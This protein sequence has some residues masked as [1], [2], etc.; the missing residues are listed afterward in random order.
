M[1]QT[2]LTQNAAG[3]VL[4]QPPARGHKPLTS[5]GSRTEP[6]QPRIVNLKELKENR[7]AAQ[8]LDQEWLAQQP[9]PLAGLEQ[10]Q[11]SNLLQFEWSEYG[12]TASDSLAAYTATLQ[13]HC[14]EERALSIGDT[15]V[16]LHKLRHFDDFTNLGLL[17]RSHILYSVD[18][19]H[20]HTVY[21]SRITLLHTPSDTP[22]LQGD[23][24]PKVTLLI[25]HEYITLETPRAEFD[26]SERAS[27][28]TT[29]H[30]RTS[31]DARNRSDS[32]ARRSVTERDDAD[33]LSEDSE[34]RRMT[35]KSTMEV[36]G[37]TFEIYGKTVIRE[38]L[39]KSTG[40]RRTMQHNISQ[41]YR[42][43]H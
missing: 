32:R 28:T 20:Q 34:A 9:P 26:G 21:L 37:E 10:Y 42:R 17:N 30:S 43:N 40:I 25:E 23:F 8:R 29:H 11:A 38:N 14:I 7:A 5:L 31:E 36:N 13:F 35:K 33:D 6:Y 18:H 2:T 22:L 15:V 12:V 16:L 1:R 24:P 19:I 3:Q 39:I 27:G 4:L 41:H